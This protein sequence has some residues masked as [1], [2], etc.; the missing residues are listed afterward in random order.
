MKRL[1]IALLFAAACANETPA[2]PPTHTMPALPPPPTAEEA[3]AIVESSPEFSEYQFTNAAYSLP[4]QRAMM[5][6]PAKDAANALKKAGWLAF[7]GA[8]N[9]VLS[10]KAESDKRFLVR[11][12]GVVDIVPLAKKEFGIITSVEGGTVKFTWSWKP[13]ELGKL[14]GAR[15]DGTQEAKATLMWEGKEW[16]VLRIDSI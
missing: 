2:P 13:N 8:G 15:Y 10:P 5:N 1:A 11:P 14:F 7:D 4:M 3:R 12:N 9:V 6:A 16:G